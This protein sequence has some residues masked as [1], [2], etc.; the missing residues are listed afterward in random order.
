MS[1]SDGVDSGISST[2]QTSI[3]AKV[4]DRDSLRKAREARSHVD[5]SKLQESEQDRV[6]TRGV[7]P[8][9]GGS[10]T[11]KRRIPRYRS[12]KTSRKR[13]ATAKALAELKAE[14]DNVDGDGFGFAQDSVLCLPCEDK[15]YSDELFDFNNP[16]SFRLMDK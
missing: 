12:R 13:R 10:L 11:Q 6:Q 14:E 7:K 8:E 15:V 9:S 1:F 2:T 4:Q 5:G 3:Q 16:P